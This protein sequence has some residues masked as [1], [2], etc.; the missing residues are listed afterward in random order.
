MID[1]L[2]QG[3]ETISK[4]LLEM[5]YGTEDTL[6]SGASLSQGEPSEPGFGGSQTSASVSAA[7]GSKGDQNI[8]REQEHATGLT[9]THPTILELVEVYLEGQQS[10]V[11]PKA[12]VWKHVLNDL[13]NR[14]KAYLGEGGT[15]PGNLTLEALAYACIATDTFLT[16]KGFGSVCEKLIEHEQSGKRFLTDIGPDGLDQIKKF[17]KGNPFR[18]C[19]ILMK[20]A[21][22]RG[23]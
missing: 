4:W 22:H 13:R 18:V 10:E 9:A 6:P 12:S 1:S 5:R 7:K 15:K 17:A 21:D 11:K 16:S 20:N 3:A 19:E 14:E 23:E 8:A 2:M